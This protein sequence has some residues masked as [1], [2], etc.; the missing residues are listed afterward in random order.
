MKRLLLATASA[1]ALSSA[2]K[3]QGIAVFDNAAV[4]QKAMQFGQE[5]SRWA[6][7]AGQMKTQ[8]DQLV[9]VYNSVTGPR[10]MGAIASQLGNF[11]VQMPGI[12]NSQVVNALSGNMTWGNAAALAQSNTYA[13]PQGSDAE[14][15]EMALRRL[16]LANL[17]QDARDA[18][19]AAE[20]R[21]AA[22]GELRAKAGQTTDIKESMD[23][24]ARVAAE[25]AA[26]QNA[27]ERSQRM[28]TLAATQQQIDAM[29]DREMGRQSSAT[30]FENTKG[31]WDTKW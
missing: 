14:A 22:I 27:N 12:P 11:G 23:L 13:L 4:I 29:R 16:S 9:G 15:R 25:Q 30:W 8:I 17:Q 20:T 1:L 28:A 26:L 31:V 5:M 18:I 10:P 24:N 21:T 19:G 3:A 6:T 7:Q 2:A